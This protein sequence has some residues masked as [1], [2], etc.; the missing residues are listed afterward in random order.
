MHLGGRGRM[1]RETLKKR[2]FALATSSTRRE[3]G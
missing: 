2:M 3:Y 1:T